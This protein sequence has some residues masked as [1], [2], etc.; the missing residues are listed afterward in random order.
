[1]IRLCSQGYTTSPVAW[2]TS[3][4]R[5][6]MVKFAHPAWGK[7]PTLQNRLHLIRA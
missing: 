2:V 5:V 6:A 4:P 7:N 1:M 3:D